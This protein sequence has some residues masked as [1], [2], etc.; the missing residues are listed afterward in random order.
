VAGAFGPRINAAAGFTS[1]GETEADLGER[2]MKNKSYSI[3]QLSGDGRTWIRDCQRGDAAFPCIDLLRMDEE[4]IGTLAAYLASDDG[5]L[6][7]EA[8]AFSRNVA[9]EV[10]ELR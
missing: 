3:E 10:R 5:S 6:D 9:A 4:D 7:E 8:L 2:M 1:P